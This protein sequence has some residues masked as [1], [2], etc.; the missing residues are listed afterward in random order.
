M[1]P[2]W[3][4]FLRRASGSEGEGAGLWGQEV[5]LPPPFPP[6]GSVATHHLACPGGESLCLG[7]SSPACHAGLPSGQ[8]A[9]G[10][11]TVLVGAGH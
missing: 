11:V 10:A 5:H 2:G 8:A 4:G 1:A 6:G 3:V 9:A 7:A